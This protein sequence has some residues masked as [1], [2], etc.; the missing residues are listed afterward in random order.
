MSSAYG[1]PIR[2][3]VEIF[4]HYFGLKG[5]GAVIRVSSSLLPC[6]GVRITIT[7]LQPAAR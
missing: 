6:I 5:A 4:A 1:M 2:R 7:T 3:R